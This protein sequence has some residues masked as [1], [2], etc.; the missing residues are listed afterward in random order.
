M[1]E[2]ETIS[3]LLRKA[4]EQ[5]SQVKFDTPEFDAK[6]LLQ[7]VCGYT[8]AQLISNSN[9]PLGDQLCNEFWSIVQRRLNHEPVHRILGYRE[10]YGREFQLC[11]DT[12]IPRPDTETLVDAVIQF[13][14]SSVLEIGTGSGVIAVSLAAELNQVEI[15]ATDISPN[16]LKIASK[17]A[18]MH[19]VESRIIFAEAD[20]YEGIKGQ[21]D[22]IVSNPPYIPSQDIK[23]LQKEVQFFDPPRALDGGENGL[24]FYCRIFENAGAF[25]KYGGKILVEIGIGQEDDVASIA[26]RYGFNDVFVIKDLNQVNR[27]VIAGRKD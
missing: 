2:A 1:L 24:D 17:N 25:L 19:E 6:L 20:L 4:A 7:S 11:D 27:V 5:F 18:E 15:L 13:A 9:E 10:F 22:A 12:L 14:P 23:D 8:S 16:A 21:F 3:S 26:R